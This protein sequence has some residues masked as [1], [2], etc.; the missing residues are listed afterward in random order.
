MGLF[1]E[2]DIDSIPADPNFVEAARYP[3]NVARADVIKQRDGEKENLKITFVIDKEGNPYHG[4]YQSK[5]YT[6]HED[7]V[8]EPDGT[9]NP[10]VVRDNAYLKKGLKALGVTN[11]QMNTMKARDMVANELFKRKPCVIIVNNY[12]DNE[13]NGKR[14]GVYDVLPPE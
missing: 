13:G 11:E 9:D 12:P 14:S 1:G 4:R 3:A 5:W 10:D 6:L 2:M 7:Y 8:K